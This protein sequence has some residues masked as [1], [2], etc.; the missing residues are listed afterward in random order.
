MA[1]ERTLVLVKPDGVQRGLVGEV[2]GRLE[3]RG[4]RLVA[5]RLLRIDDELAGRQYAEHAAKPFYAGLVRF[6][7]ASPVVA[8]VWEGEGAVAVVRA[9]M[10][11]TDPAAAAPGTIRGDLGLTMPNNVVHG[12]DS[13][14]RAAVEV[15]LFFRAEELVAWESALRPWVEGG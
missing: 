4:L 7:T 8:M 2:V 1:A 15:G 12:S 3:R 13:V 10:G 6:M 9:T 14:E 5:I 11:A